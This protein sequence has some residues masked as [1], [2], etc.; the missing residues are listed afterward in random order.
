MKEGY[1]KCGSYCVEGDVCP[2]TDVYLKKGKKKNLDTKTD[3]E[4]DED[5]F[6]I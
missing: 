6:K 3:T 2:I 1:K 4:K 5:V